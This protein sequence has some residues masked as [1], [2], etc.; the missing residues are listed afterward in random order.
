MASASPEPRTPVPAPAA[1]PARPRLDS[2]DVVRGAVMVLMALDHARDYFSNVRLNF[3]L[4]SELVKASTPVFFTRWVTHFCAPVFVFLA[5]TAAYL[6]GT[7]KTRRELSWFLLTRGLWLVVLE[8]TVVHFC[9]TFSF[10]LQNT[11]VQV[12][13]AIGVS[14]IVLAGLVFLPTWVV[15]AFGVAMIAVHNAF[16][17]VRP[18]QL[19]E[20]ASL[21]EILHVPAQAHLLPGWNAFVAYPLVPWIGVMAAGYG[22]GAL[23][24]LDAAPRRRALMRIGIGA[25]LLFVVLRFTNLYGDPLPWTFQPG[26]GIRTVLSFLNC[27]KYPPSLLYLLMT[28][29]PAI[30]ALAL[31]DGREA[32]GLGKPLVV[33]GRVPLFFYVFHIL[34][35]HVAAAVYALGKYGRRALEINPL[36]LPADYGFGLG[37]VYLAW[38]GAVVLLYPACAWFAR[39]KA[40]SRSPFLSYL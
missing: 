26:H 40:R 10:A 35:L 19:G 3:F 34:L 28:L 25:S 36:A 11:F 16:D 18:E 14:M 2:I 33:Y 6:S 24:R 9:W 39:L 5:G 7:R 30:V 4:A 8:L 17:S 21:W 22:F 13:W 20:A 32:R 37:V 27:E 31:L 1:R 38:I 12:I 15:T 29:G 23:Y